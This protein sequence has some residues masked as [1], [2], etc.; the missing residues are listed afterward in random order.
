VSTYDIIDKNYEI[1]RDSSY[2]SLNEG[3]SLKD[4]S[5]VRR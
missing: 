1:M 4:I 2:E 5:M 3:K